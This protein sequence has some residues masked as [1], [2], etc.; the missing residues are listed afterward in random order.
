MKTVDVDVAT[1][2][3]GSGDTGREKRKK[4]DVD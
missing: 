4:T 2:E 3:V 1:S